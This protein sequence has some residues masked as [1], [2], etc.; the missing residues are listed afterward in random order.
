MI[1]NLGTRK[2]IAKLVYCRY[3]GNLTIEEKNE[4][5]NEVG[6]AMDGYE[7]AIDETIKWLEHNF[8]MPDDFEQKLREYLGQL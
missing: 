5:E 2:K 6:A 3:G 4:L 7:L 1:K 8:N